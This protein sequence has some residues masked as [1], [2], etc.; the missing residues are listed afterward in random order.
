MKQYLTTLEAKVAK[1]ADVALP[2]Q[3]SEPG[4]AVDRTAAPP[5]QMAKTDKVPPAS[6][7]V[8]N[9]INILSKIVKQEPG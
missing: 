8:K 7:A 4:E 9:E 5:S 1:L 6:L 3:I 2:G